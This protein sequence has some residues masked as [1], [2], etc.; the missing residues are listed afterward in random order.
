MRIP[1]LK[2][3]RQAAR[4]FRS[5]LVSGT[6]IL[7]YHRISEGVNDPFAMSVSPRNFA[8]QMSVVRDLTKPISLQELAQRLGEGKLPKRSV[9]LTM[10]DG[11]ADNL[12]GALPLLKRYEIPATIFVVSSSLG[13]EFWWDEVVR[14]VFTEGVLTTERCLT[15]AGQ[16]FNWQWRADRDFHKQ[17]EQ[18]LQI[19][20]WALRP[21]SEEKRQKAM[22]ELRHSIRDVQMEKCWHRALTPSELRTLADCPLIEIGSHTHTHPALAELSHTEQRDE[23]QQSKAQLEE[24]L[25]RPVTSFSYPNGSASTETRTLVREAGFVS[26]CTSDNDIAWRGSDP[27]HLPRF[28][29]PDW[30][31]KQFSRWLSKWL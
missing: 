25:E 31:G 2:N 24:L 12:H 28:W 4:R 3:T 21:L 13:G 26:A 6:I 10:D 7:G 20:Y 9:V 29:V 14:I 23:I 30:D 27:L 1:G 16:E 22:E 17:Q 11:Y 8:E 18:L 15:I 19:L 5:R